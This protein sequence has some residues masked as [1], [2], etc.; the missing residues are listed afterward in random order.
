MRRG[1][2]AYTA[3]YGGMASFERQMERVKMRRP[4][5][6]VKGVLT[7]M[8]R[9]P[10]IPIPGGRICIPRRNEEDVMASLFQTFV[11]KE[12]ETDPR[13]VPR[14]GYVVVDAGGFVGLWTIRVSKMVGNSGR[15]IVVEPNPSTLP[16][17]ETNIRLNGLKNVTVVSRALG[18]RPGQAE[19]FFPVQG[20][21]SA[22]SSLF[23]VHVEHVVGYLD[24]KREDIVRTR[25]EMT[26]IDEL[27]HDQGVGRLDILKLD[28][29]GAEMSALEGAKEAL[30]GR[31]VKRLIVE[32][33]VDICSE[34]QVATLLKG[35][36]YEI[37]H[38]MRTPAETGEGRALV[39][40]RSGSDG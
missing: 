15:V 20:S 9:V 12:Y 3:I 27:I 30:K 11:E 13:Y 5:L 10:T 32:V 28:V 6:V 8:G 4:A 26:T 34:D 14:P 38:V 16:E 17:L 7:L 22:S 33:H 1:F 19:L 37:D 36:G 23:Q 40:A 25:T 2:P 31:L 29:E 18:S 35:N 24:G 39:F 21:G